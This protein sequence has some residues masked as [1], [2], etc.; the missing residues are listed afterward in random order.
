MAAAGEGRMVA[1]EAPH[2]AQTFDMAPQAIDIEVEI[3][4]PP[5]KRPYGSPIYK[6]SLDTHNIIDPSESLMAEAGKEATLVKA[7]DYAV[8]DDED[9]SKWARH[10][11]RKQ[12]RLSLLQQPSDVC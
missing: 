8:V 2:N 10:L 3:I 1:P 12:E 11:T 4:V 7:D 5:K 6:V 9:Y